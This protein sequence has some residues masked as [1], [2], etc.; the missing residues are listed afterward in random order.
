MSILKLIGPKR[1]ERWIPWEY[2][3]WCRK[4]KF[5]TFPCVSVWLVV[6]HRRPDTESCW[7]KYHTV[8]LP[9][10][11][12]LT[13][14]HRKYVRHTDEMGWELRVKNLVQTFSKQWRVKHKEAWERERGWRRPPLWKLGTPC[15]ET[16]LKCWTS[17]EHESC[18]SSRKSSAKA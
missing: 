3:S 4:R 12:T 9:S 6:V 14:V 15:Y 2:V 16:T 11:L 5:E 7:G 1:A 13:S 17:L 10:E 18:L 8:C